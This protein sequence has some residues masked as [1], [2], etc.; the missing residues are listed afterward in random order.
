MCVF[1]REATIFA[2]INYGRKRIPMWS[3]YTASQ[4]LSMLSGLVV[5][6]LAQV[7]QAALWDG[8]LVMSTLLLFVH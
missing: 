5:T 3:P 6:W 8:R 1:E 2:G 7:V 4:F